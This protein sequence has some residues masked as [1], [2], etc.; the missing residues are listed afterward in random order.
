MFPFPPVAAWGPGLIN[1]GI[2][3]LIGSPLLFGYYCYLANFS[4]RVVREALEAQKR[5]HGGFTVVRTGR[6]ERARTIQFEFTSPQSSLIAVSVNGELQSYTE[7]HVPIRPKWMASKK[8]Q[9]VK[10]LLDTAYVGGLASGV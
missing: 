7:D 10:E 2:L 8:S 4:T 3:L 5:G 6:D 1:A 9:L